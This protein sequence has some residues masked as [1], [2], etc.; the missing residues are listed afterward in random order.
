MLSLR[1]YLAHLHISVAYAHPL[2]CIFSRV[3]S[4]NTVHTSARFRKEARASPDSFLAVE[5]KHNP[6]YVALESSRLGAKHVRKF[7]TQFQSTLGVGNHLFV[8]EGRHVFH[9]DDTG[10][11]DN[12][13]KVTVSTPITGGILRFEKKDFGV[14]LVHSHFLRKLLFLTT[15]CIFQRNIIPLITHQHLRWK[16]K[17]D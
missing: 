12:Y 5:V 4:R 13:S 16:K 9:Q 1:V 17:T 3:Y 7:Y 11:V 8:V 14:S 2:R 6:S 15:F 10:T